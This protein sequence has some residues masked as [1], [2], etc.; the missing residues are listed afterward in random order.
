MALLMR[1]SYHILAI[2]IV[3]LFM[4]KP[5]LRAVHQVTGSEEESGGLNT[6]LSDLL[7]FTLKLFS[8]Q[9]CSKPTTT[10]F[11]TSKSY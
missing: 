8:L 4:Q 3:P 5:R 9:D 6:G 1:D 7:F 2:M 10:A 11:L